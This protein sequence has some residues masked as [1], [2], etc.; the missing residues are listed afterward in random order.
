M[1]WRPKIVAVRHPLA[2]VGVAADKSK[3]ATTTALDH[4]PPPRPNRAEVG[5]AS[6]VAQ[7]HA[8]N[9]PAL[10]LKGPFQTRQRLRIFRWLHV[11]QGAT[12]PCFH[13]KVLEPKTV[14]WRRNS[15]RNSSVSSSRKTTPQPTTVAKVQQVRLETQ[16][17]EAPSSAT[18][19]ILDL[20]LRLC[21]RSP[22]VRGHRPFRKELIG[23]VRSVGSCVRLSIPYTLTQ[24][25]NRARTVRFARSA[26]CAIGA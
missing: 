24:D 19:T 22:A 1:P 12:T 21:A 16:L 13:E 20:P 18:I 3:L 14:P 23:A 7:G 5:R 9:R 15:S 26:D 4:A 25:K 17:Y 2:S 8:T 10:H 11:R 6:A